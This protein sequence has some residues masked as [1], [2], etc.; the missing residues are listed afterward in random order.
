VSTHYR[1]GKNGR[2]KSNTR[3]FPP[4]TIYGRRINLFSMLGKWLKMRK[5]TITRDGRWSAKRKPVGLISLLGCLGTTTL[6]GATAPSATADPSSGDRL[7]CSTYCQ[8]AGGYGSAVGP[9][10]PPAVTLENTGTAIADA[11]GY[12]PVTLKCHRTVQCLGVIRIFAN[13]AGGGHSDLLVNAG[14]TRTI[15][16]PLDAATIAYLRSHGPTP[17][18]VQIDA[19]AQDL[20]LGGDHRVPYDEYA[21]ISGGE[22]ALTVAAPG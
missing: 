12:V 6:L 21:S 9:Q 4:P 22:N 1:V 19:A 2:I 13:G 17:F 8:T 18:G 5:Q 20:N 7:G 10:P 15:A 3:V 14:A 11:D 16:V